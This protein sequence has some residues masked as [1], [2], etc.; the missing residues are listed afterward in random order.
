MSLCGPEGP[1]RV[2]TWFKAPKL[3]VHIHIYIRSMALVWLSGPDSIMAL[4]LDLL[5]A[6]PEGQWNHPALAQQL[7]QQELANLRHA[8][9][10]GAG[11]E[12]W[13]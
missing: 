11:P 8:E 4:Y 1:V 13:I 9:V 6:L 10:E 5:R 2:P 7:A 3:H 12:G